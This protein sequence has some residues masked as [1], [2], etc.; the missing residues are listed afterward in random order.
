MRGTTKKWNMV[1]VVPGA[2]SAPCL[3][4]GHC[5]FVH[6]LS[7]L[8]SVPL[9]VQ[10]FPGVFL[11]WVGSLLRTR[12]GG[13]TEDAVG[14]GRGMGRSMRAAL[15]CKVTSSVVLIGRVVRMK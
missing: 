7:V 12:T 10:H 4:R 11:S 14:T 13:G 5:E 3:S 2:V 9:E 6:V 15:A 1:C 8:F